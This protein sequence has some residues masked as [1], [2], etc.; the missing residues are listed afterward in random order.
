MTPLE[1]LPGIIPALT[2]AGLPPYVVPLALGAAL[3][4]L[5]LWLVVRARVPRKARPAGKRDARGLL[6]RRASGGVRELLAVGR[7]LT[8]RREWRYRQP[9]VVMLGERGAGKSSISESISIGR[10]ETLLAKEQRLSAPDS[11]WIFFNRGVLIDIGGRTSDGEADPTDGT[12][13][14]RRRWREMLESLD[15][16][17]PE[18]PLDAAVLT[19]SARTL[20]NASGA[21]LNELAARLYRQLWE[22]RQRLDLTFPVYLVVGQCDAVPGFDA[23]WSAQ[24][25]ALRQQIFGWSNPHALNLSFSPEWVD[26]AFTTLDQSLSELQM[27]AAARGVPLIDP[28]RFFLFPRRFAALAPP[29][30]VVLGQLFRHG[31]LHEDFLFRGLYF[32][33]PLSDAPA[34]GDRPPTSDTPPPGERT[35]IAFIDE[36]FDERIFR[37]IN[38]A[39]PT[40]QGVLSRNRLIRRFQLTMLGLAALLVVAL[41]AS[42]WSLNQ[43]IS[44]AGRAHTLVANEMPRQRPGEPCVRRAPLYTL[45]EDVARIHLDLRY[46]TIPLSWFDRRVNTINRKEIADGAFEGVIFPALACRLEQRAHRLAELGERLPSLDGPLKDPSAEATEAAIAALRDYAAEAAALSRDMARFRELAHRREE[47]DENLDRFTGLVSGLYRAPLP[48]SVLHSRG[49]LRA[50]LAQVEY[51]TP[52]KLPAG[53]ESEVAER[54]AQLSLEA[55]GQLQLRLRH[56]TTLLTALE[57][58]PSLDDIQRVYRWLHEVRVEWLGD[59]QTRNRC[60]ALRHHLTPDLATLARHGLSGKSRAMGAELSARVT[61]PLDSKRCEQPAR[62]LLASLRIAPYGPLFSDQGGQLGVTPWM[63]RELAGFN[64][65]LKLDFMQMKARHPFQCRLPIRGWNRETL[66]EVARYLRQWEAFAQ[67]HDGAER[68]AQPTLFE[69][70][71][72]V[73]LGTLV[74]HLFNDAQRRER[75]TES[76]SGLWSLSADEQRVAAKSEAFQALID[77]L[78]LTLDQYRRLGFGASQSRVLQCARDYAADTLGRI[79]TLG[80]GSR[81]YEVGTH[82][83]PLDPDTPTFDLGTTAQ[84]KGWLTRQLSRSQVLAGYAE[85]FVTFL[86]NSAPVNDANLAAVDSG[87]YWEGTID[88]I[89]RLVQFKDPTGQAAVLEGFITNQLSALTQANCH[90]VLGDYPRPPYGDDL[91][92]RS[93]DQLTLLADWYCRDHAVATLLDDYL[94]LARRFNGELAGRFPF[95]PLTAGDADPT[96]VRNFFRDYAERR[97]TLEKAL[98][99]LRTGEN[100]G[101]WAEIHAFINGLDRAAALFDATLAAR[102]GAQ[103]VALKVGF[104]H[105]PKRSPGSEQVIAWELEAGVESATWPN[106]GSDLNWHFGDPLRLALSWADLSPVGPMADGDQPDL[107]VSGRTAEFSADGPWALLRLE[108]RHRQEPLSGEHQSVLRFTVPLRVN[109]GVPRHATALHARMYLALE[110]GATDPKT[111]KVAPL[112]IPARLPETAPMPK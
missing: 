31:A 45:L 62:T 81:L 27:S 112:T 86:K 72:R 29:L 2:P 34:A 93:R 56:G 41:G 100:G 16:H 47:S 46:W 64:D 71:G 96:L 21:D 97:E 19:L 38:L 57:G 91:F 42:L 73:H 63:E 36:L 83:G 24:P 1:N 67:R 94:A 66:G 95:G 106:G 7:Y 22:M 28:D 10:R 108:R 85:P 74:D 49:L 101:E 20:L 103:P 4:L 32:S 53:L 25:K 5:A 12:E 65:L 17:R 60:A 59:D 55:A 102:D 75:I 51:H 88:E 80:E 107:G 78:L 70:V 61:A 11:E 111:Q 13:S 76:G 105:L 68:Q 23:F 6:R 69:R 40:R 44:A 79:Q 15:H 37:E 3:L 50:A 54:L 18:R 92:S 14:D 33:G 90:R 52:L 104:R 58:R 110:T 35:D 98:T 109:G 82:L 77:P 39:R 99:G 84:T 89:N 9:W 48:K 43:Q 26:D 8:T 87:A 30:K